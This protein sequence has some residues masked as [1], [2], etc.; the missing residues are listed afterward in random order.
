MRQ[1]ATKREVEQLESQIHE[2]C[3]ADNPVSVR[4]VFYRMTDPSL[5]VPVEKTEK[6][7]RQVQRRIA[8]MRERGALPYPW[9]VDSSRM[10]WHVLTYDDPADYVRASADSYRFDLWADVDEEVEVWCE[11]RSIAGVLRDTCGELAV[12][13]YPTSGFSSK[14]LAWEA[15]QHYT[16]PTRII[17]VGD[18]DPAGVLID[19]SLE[20]ELKRHTDVELFFFRVAI[21]EIQIAEY[22]LPKKPRKESDKRSPSIVETVEAEAMPAPILRAVVRGWVGGYLPE[23]R[24]EYA[25]LMDEQGQNFLRAFGAGSSSSPV[26]VE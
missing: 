9:I 4:H 21:N 23:G 20:R 19:V 17:Y 24:L 7:Y 16:K 15:A 18:Y 1:R 6:G 11:S 22:D 8:L 26:F 13:L 25:K 10:G 3:R 2:V 12:S 14:T 5:P